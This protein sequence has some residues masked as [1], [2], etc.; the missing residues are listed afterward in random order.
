MTVYIFDFVVSN[1]HPIVYLVEITFSICVKIISV[2][3]FVRFIEFEYTVHLFLDFVILFTD[4]I[5]FLFLSFFIRI[6]S[7]IRLLFFLIFFIFRSRLVFFFLI[8]F[9]FFVLVGL[10]LIRH[11]FFMMFYILRI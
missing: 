6:L 1:L 2:E 7:L 4:P 8:F 5:S 11:L 10:A 3:Y 9:M